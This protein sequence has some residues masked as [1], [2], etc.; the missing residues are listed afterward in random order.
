MNRKHEPFIGLIVSESGIESKAFTCLKKARDHAKA[1]PQNEAFIM[2]DIKGNLIFRCEGVSIDSAPV[3]SN[4]KSV[5]HSA[6]RVEHLS[7]ECYTRHVHTEIAQLRRERK[8]EAAKAK[9]KARNSYHA[10]QKRLYKAPSKCVT[11]ALG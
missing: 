3:K 7:K 6:P 1:M 9:R 2:T 11:I 10:K 4:S 5:F 8:K